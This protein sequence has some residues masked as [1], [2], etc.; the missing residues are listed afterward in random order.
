MKE[1]G[2]PLM[3]EGAVDMSGLVGAAALDG[4]VEMNAMVERLGKG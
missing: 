1:V 2:L 4:G 3:W